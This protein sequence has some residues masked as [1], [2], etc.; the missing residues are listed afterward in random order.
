MAEGCRRHGIATS[1]L[2]RW[3]IQFG[4]T[5]RKTLQLATVIIADGT[6]NQVPALSTLR[7]LARSPDEMTAI[8][9]EIARSWRDGAASSPYAAHSIGSL[10]R[11][12]ARN[13][14]IQLQPPTWHLCWT[15]VAARSPEDT[16][17]SAGASSPSLVRIGP[18]GIVHEQH[19]E[20][21]TSGSFDE[22]S[23]FRSQ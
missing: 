13:L 12:M 23:W 7:D 15:S 3:R 14:A 21:G 22:P 10:Q 1:L 8:V 19:R 6:L 5:A 9:M 20:W 4:L 2:F 11:A 17:L 18:L 16:A